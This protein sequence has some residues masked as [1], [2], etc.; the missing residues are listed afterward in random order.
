MNS[1][2]SYLKYIWTYNW[3]IWFSILQWFFFKSS[4]IIYFCLNFFYHISLKY[5]HRTNSK[6]QNEKNYFPQEREEEG[7]EEVEVG[8]GS[9]VS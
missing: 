9:M 3:I 8:V 1:Q 5:K 2:L 4:S 6:I 7:E